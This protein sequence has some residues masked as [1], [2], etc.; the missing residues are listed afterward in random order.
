MYKSKYLFSKVERFRE[1]Q[2]DAV[3]LFDYDDIRYATI[4]Y[5]GWC[6]YWQYDVARLY[7]FTII[8]FF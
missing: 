7:L 2:F 3:L 4:L 5:F 6:M 1:F 8:P